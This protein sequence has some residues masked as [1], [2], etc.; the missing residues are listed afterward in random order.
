MVE[1]ASMPADLQLRYFAP[2]ESGYFPFVAHLLDLLGRNGA[3]GPLMAQE[4]L[5]WKWPPMRARQDPAWRWLYI[6]Q[7]APSGI[8]KIGLSAAPFERMRVLPNDYR[9]GGAF[10]LIAIAPF[11]DRGHERALCRLFRDSRLRGDEWFRD[12][13]ATRILCWFAASHRHS[14]AHD[15]G[16]ERIERELVSVSDG[17]AWLCSGRIPDWKQLRIERQQKLL[18]MRPQRSAEARER[19]A[20]RRARLANASPT[21]AA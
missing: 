19:W 7:H 18:A 15:Q 8:V 14:T 20:R 4:L 9:D 16:W 11:C 2:M 17:L 3:V 6:A 21:E 13:P 12:T 5:G 10:S 1:R